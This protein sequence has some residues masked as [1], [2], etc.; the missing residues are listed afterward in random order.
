MLKHAVLRHFPKMASGFT[1]WNPMGPCDYGGHQA[2]NHRFFRKH[3]AEVCHYM[4]LQCLYCIPSTNKGGPGPAPS[5]PWE[6]LE[7]VAEW[8]MAKVPL[9]KSILLETI[10]RLPNRKQETE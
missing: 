9:G 5:K 1:I 8:A 10:T 3:R 2:G 4:L 7:E 6:K